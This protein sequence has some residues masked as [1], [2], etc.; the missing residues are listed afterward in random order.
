MRARSSVR[1][2]IRLDAR[3]AGLRVI[4]CARTRVLG[5]WRQRYGSDQECRELVRRR[6]AAPV[7]VRR[8]LGRD[9]LEGIRAALTPMTLRYPRTGHADRSSHRVAT[10][11]R[12]ALDLAYGYSALRRRRDVQW[13]YPPRKRRCAAT[14]ST[15]SPHAQRWIGPMPSSPR[16]ECSAG[17][18]TG[19]APLASIGLALRPSPR[20]RA[21]SI[22]R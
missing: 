13:G 1:Q 21:G 2:A 12:C 8:R 6:S 4:R 10:D 9:E 16:E 19:L 7:T 5:P 20:C 17:C 11:Y 18:M 14:T 22:S 3:R 15:P